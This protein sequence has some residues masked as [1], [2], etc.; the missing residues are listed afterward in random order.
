M[1]T[2]TPGP[3]RW[4]GWNYGGDDFWTRDNL[5]GTLWAGDKC[6]ARAGGNDSGDS[7]IMFYSYDADMDTAAANARLIE[8][9]PAL[10]EALEAALNSM[11]CAECDRA[12]PCD[13]CRQAE[14]LTKSAIAAAKGED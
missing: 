5:Q 12:V 4:I 10:L 14:A 3:W 9:A 11:A 13:Q 1:S 2:H 7:Y 6:V 8:Q